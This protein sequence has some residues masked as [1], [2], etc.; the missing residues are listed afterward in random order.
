M[1]NSL[2][3]AWLGG[4][5]YGRQS[6]YLE[7]LWASGDNVNHD[8]SVA[9]VQKNLDAAGITVPAGDIVNGVYDS[10]GAFYALPECIVSNPTNVV[11]KGLGEAEESDD[12]SEEVQM[13]RLRQRGGNGKRAVDS[14]DIVTVKARRSD[15]VE[16]DLIIR[17][18]EEDSVQLLMQRFT[19]ELGVSCR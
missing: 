1:P 19:E 11:N 13:G 15:G 14:G 8:A 4:Q 16:K 12:A 5:K 17:A 18:A 10:F 3:P 2:I 6:E 9:T 7:V